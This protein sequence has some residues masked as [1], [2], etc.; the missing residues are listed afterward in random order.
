MNA[1]NDNV[2]ILMSNSE[3]VGIEDSPKG[4][5]LLPRVFTLSQNH[6]NPFNPSTTISFEIPGTASARRPVELIV[7]D[8]RGRHVKTLIDSDLAPGT[9]MIHWNGSDEHGLSV[10]SGIYLYKLNAG[11][12]T[13]TRKMTILK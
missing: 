2:A 11:G 1:G 7:Y 4:N 3:D 10:A 13:H 6:P 12:E 9:H 8:L 5:L